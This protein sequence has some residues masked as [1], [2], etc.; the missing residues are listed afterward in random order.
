VKIFRYELDTGEVPNISTRSK[1][2]MEWSKAMVDKLLGIESDGVDE[3]ALEDEIESSFDKV[4]K[5]P[6][7]LTMFDW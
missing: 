1:E 4:P 6:R 3:E 5:T 2:I 7:G